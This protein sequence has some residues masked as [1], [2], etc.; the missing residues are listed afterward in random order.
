MKI[1]TETVIQ[2]APFIKLPGGTWR[3]LQPFTSRSK[4]EAEYYIEEWRRR[5]CYPP[6]VETKVM[7]RTVTRTSTEWVEVEAD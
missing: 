5:A 2:Y 6:N 7:R 3:K 4:A 1:R